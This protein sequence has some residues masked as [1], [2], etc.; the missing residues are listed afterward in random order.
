MKYIP[1]KLFRF[2]E[3]DKEGKI[4]AE[5]YDMTMYDAYVYL[6]S[7]FTIEDYKDLDLDISGDDG[8]I[9]LTV[10]KERITKFLDMADDL[11][12]HEEYIKKYLAFGDRIGIDALRYIFSRKLVDPDLLEQYLPSK[13]L[14]EKDYELWHWLIELSCGYYAT[15]EG[16][17]SIELAKKLALG[18][19]LDD[20]SEQM[21]YH[22]YK[23]PDKDKSEC[24]VP[25]TKSELLESIEKEK[26]VM[27][28]TKRKK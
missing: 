16:L 1:E 26:K 22:Y 19:S 10:P 3:L 4:R 23:Y 6:K 24:L 2:L 18:E 25:F 17:L 11:T 27:Q 15:D 12:K 28:R 13:E 7:G 14:I 8:K 21:T 20:Y 5:Y 9:I